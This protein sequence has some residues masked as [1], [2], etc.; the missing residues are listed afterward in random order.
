LVKLL[1][2]FRHGIAVLVLLGE[3]EDDLDAV[4]FLG[5]P[6]GK[7][8]ERIRP[9]EDLFDL[10]QESVGGRPVTDD[11]VDLF[12]VLVDDELG[13][14]GPDVVLFVDGVAVLVPAA[15][16]VDDD[17]GVEEIGVFG[18]FVELL[19]QQFAAPSATREKVDEDELVVLFGLGQRL[20]E[21]ARQDVGRLGRG[22][23]R[24]E[25]DAGD[26]GHFFH[27]RLLS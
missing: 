1:D 5:V 3:L 18:V 27:A 24:H 13:R 12:P 10:F 16:A 20:V 4:G 21:G 19:D 23:G 2:L 25:E 26:G 7:G 6:F 14:S 22:E 15:G 11:P 8:P 17:V 9:R